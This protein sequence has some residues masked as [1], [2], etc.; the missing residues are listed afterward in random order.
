TATTTRCTDATCTAFLSTS[1]F[2]A[3]F[4]VIAAPTGVLSRWPL[5]ETAGTVA[6]DVEAG[7]NGT[8]TNGVTL[9]QAGACATTATAVH[10]DGS[11]QQ[12]VE[13][14]HHDD[15]LLD[16][17]TITL[18]ANI[19]VLP[20]PDADPEH[21]LFSKDSN[22]RD[23]GGHVTIRVNADGT[24]QARLQS[25]TANFEVISAAITA[26]AWF[27]LA[28][29]WGAGGMKLYID[30]GAPVTN[31]YTG[32]LGTTSGGIGN[33]E[34]ITLGASQ[35]VSDPDFGVSPLRRW[36]HGFLDDVR[37]YDSALSAAEILALASCPPPLPLNIVKRAFWPDG[38]PIPTGATIP[39]GVTF[40]FLLY[41]NNSGGAITD[42]SVR[43]VLNAAFQYQPATI[44]VDN[45]VGN[46]VI[47]VCTALEEQAIFTAVDL[48]VPP[49]S[50]AVDLGDVAS[51]TGVNID[52]GDENVANGRLDINANMV[53]AMLFSVKMP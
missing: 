35:L 29:S 2:S 12:Y 8:Y 23:T 48:A 24:T 7:H 13:I 22:G 19:D 42:V 53:W 43:D 32:G 18:W 52:A 31:P 45:S 30:G 37:I 5:D 16:N 20:N 25:T 50:D 47:A 10:F 39:S 49:L 33:F 51:N 41:I 34:P 26:Q 38:T 28:F 27:H 17:G 15:Y 9:N 46:C 1:E 36:M 4:T 21:G 3:A 40:K 44:Q 14:S 11:L 6:A